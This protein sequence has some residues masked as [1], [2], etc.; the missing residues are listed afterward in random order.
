MSDD[1]S[2]IGIG[3]DSTQVRRGKKDLDDLA[4]AGNKAEQSTDRLAKASARLSSVLAG[5]SG[6]FATLGISR[7]IVETATLNQRYEELGIVL[8]TVARNAGLSATEVL[9]TADAIR[10][11]GISMI[12]SRQVVAK[13]VAAN[14]DLAQATKLSRLAQDAAVVGQINSSEALDRMVHGIVSSQ[15]EVLRGI[16]IN[17]NFEQ[18]YARLAKE[19]GVSNNA[20]SEQQKMQ[21]RLNVVLGEA[22]KLLGIYEASMAN[23]GKQLRSTERLVEDLKVKVGG[24]FSQT[25]IFAVTAYTNALKETDGALDRMTES[26]ELK[27][28]GDSVARTVAFVADSVRSVGIMFDITGKALGAMA[29]QAVAISQFDF[30]TAFSIQGDFNK[31]FDASIASMSKMRDLVESQIVQR[32]MLAPAIARSSAAMKKDN[33]AWERQ[34][35]L[36]DAGAETAK[37]F[38]NPLEA[39]KKRQEELSEQLKAGAINQDV[40]SR[41]LKA[42]NDEFSRP[43]I[44]E[45]K[46]STEQLNKAQQK[47]LSIEGEYVKLLEIERRQRQDLLKPYEESSKRATES[48]SQMQDEVRALKLSR[49]S[50]I[51]LAQA[52][53]LVTIAK[54]E[55]RRASI[56]D[57]D[58]I[59]QINDEISARK[60]I[61]DLIPMQAELEAATRR[62][63]NQQSQLWI[64]MGRNIQTSLSNSIFDF[65]NDGLDGMVRN[66]KNA[67]LRILSEFAAMKL[68]KAIGL[69]QMF[70]GMAGG[71]IGGTVS[72]GGMM[73]NLA[74]IGTNVMSGIK[75][76]F[77]IPSMIGRGMSML[78]GSFGAFGEGMLG[79][80]GSGAFSAAGGAGTAFIGGAG[81]AIGGTGMGVTAGLGSMAAAAAGPLV[82]A[83]AADMIFRALAGNKTTGNKVIDSIPI[84]GSLGALFFGHGPM[85]FRQQVAIGEASSEGFDGRVTDVFRA[86]GGLFV[87]NKHKEQ[88]AANAQ[89]LLDLFG[90]TI[91]GY[92]DVSK[93]FAKNLGLDAEVINGYSKEI[94]LESEKGKTL[95]Q[96]AIQ[97]MLSG[98]GD[99]MANAVLPSISTLKKSG[100]TAMQTLTRVSGEF[101]ALASG[102]VNLGAS[103][104]Y[105][106][107]LVKSMSFEARTSL[108]ELAG[109]VES[110]GSLTG[111]FAENF[112]TSAE[113]LAPVQE[114]LINSLNELGLSTSMTNDEFKGLVQSLDITNEIRISLLRL[115]P[116]LLQVNAATDA[117]IQAE[118]SLA[119]ERRLSNISAVQGAFS[120]LQKTVETR[121]NEITENYNTQ[122][123]VLNG[124]IE[125]ITGSISRLQSFSDSLRSTVNDIAPMN[126]AFAR[127]IVENSIKSGNFDS[128]K[129]QFAIGA[130][131]DQSAQGFRS[132]F[133]FEREQAK[134]VGLLTRL[135][136]SADSQISE[137]QRLLDQVGAQKTILDHGFKSEMERLDSI[138]DQGQEQIDLLTGINT[139]V[140]TVAQAVEFFNL[141]N[142]QAGGSGGIMTIDGGGKMTGN[143]DITDRQINDFVNQPGVTS[144]DIY[145][146]AKEVGVSFEQYAGATGANLQDL[147]AWA[148]KNNVPVFHEGT[149]YVQ[150][151][152]PAIMKQGERVLT[153]EQ[154]SDLK[155][156]MGNDEVITA[157]NKL[158]QKFN[159]VL[160][161]GNALRVKTV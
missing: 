151:T 2:L 92:A 103:L 35:V 53:Q 83:A 29:A 148:K 76:G 79:A 21:A 118:K 116:A 99:E 142:A 39:L 51:S 138:L 54:L 159:D 59:K 110:L 146:K 69:D 136:D 126:R 81:T 27:L 109:G 33:E 73:M 26:D 128:Q 72:A 157:I 67:A 105:S 34:K 78:P 135:G 131:K 41:A 107:E 30:K 129:L 17:V 113:R 85:K 125:E 145:R 44:K 13:L 19:L 5:V 100:E 64:Q 93:G 58:A 108:V 158:V 124:R 43:G 150:K 23:A 50:Q 46:D 10:A 98:I 123:G 133:E 101:D 3:V 77:G 14:I 111:F 84:I 143:P 47:A 137:Q 48:L 95:T 90:T 152:G 139:S 25:A 38:V 141:K 4:N 22:P 16:G 91:K 60:Q 70:G 62:S 31:D 114:G 102:A 120:F 8:V 88:D 86:K 117:A 122:L 82:I 96:E 132:S 161:G 18:S 119:E 112:L 49:D 147:Y 106:R 127:R 45:R 154:N 12:E 20:L 153:S 24:L 40:Y 160:Q 97:G 28:W 56:S 65:F 121:R 63:T 140:A 68:S 104:A 6:V 66:V 156:A 74:S 52:V 80:A 134:S 15:V 144:M 32:E 155:K 7:F 130:L 75:S 55:E 87:G 61:R 57:P 36:M 1:I 71:G 11:S 115:A 94:R 9:K 42:A 37:K 89:E 149:S